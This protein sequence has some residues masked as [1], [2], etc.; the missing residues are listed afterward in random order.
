MATPKFTSRHL[1]PRQY[2]GLEKLGDAYFPAGGEFPAFSSLGCAEHVDEVLDPMP[3]GD[4]DSLKVLLGLLRFMPQW[5]LALLV[6]WLEGAPS[7]PD[8]A[9]GGALR[10]LRMGIRGLAMTLY[11]SG[12]KGARY[13]GRTPLDILDY[14]VGVYT[15]DCE[16]RSS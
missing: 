7:V 12:R 11:Y 15:G 14:R 13:T 1:S 5:K 6:R 2:R 4:R 3:A 10:F 9:G 16:A 8:W